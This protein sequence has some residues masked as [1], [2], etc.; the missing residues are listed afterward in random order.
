ML[1]A[2]I[3]FLFISLTI[4]F[5]ITVPVVNHIKGVSISNNTKTSYLLADVAA[6]DIL[7]R[8]KNNKQVPSNGSLSLNG[9]TSTIVVSNSGDGKAVVVTAN[10]Q[11]HIRKIS[12]SVQYGTGISFHYGIQAGQ[13][14][15]TMDNSSKI[16][17]NVFSGG[18]VIGENDNW[19]YGDVVS[20]NSSGWVYGIHATG[21][22]YSHTIGNTSYTTTVDKDAYYQTILNPSNT[23][24]SGAVCTSNSHCHPGS[25]DQTDVALPISDDQIFE[26]ETDAAAGGTLSSSF[27]DSFSSNTCFITTSKSLGPIKIPFNLDIKSNGGIL[28]VNGPIWVVGN[29]ITETGATI[30]M[31]SSLGSQNVAIIADN[32]SN[33]S[34]ASTISTGQS[35]AF[36]GSGSPSSFV[37]LISM[38]N[39]AENGG[40]TVAVTM[41]QGSNA[42]VAYASH[43]LIR[44]SQ[45]VGVKE[46]TGYKISLS[47]SANVTYDTGLP[48]TLFE[49][50]PSGGYNILGWGEI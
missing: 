11:N 38:N 5:G 46:A 18:S 7:Y 24:V 27:C 9:A 42:L 23:K 8:L 35:S 30:K 49:A 39:S 40:S 19:I 31:A 16:I 36:Q 45:S 47:Q 22:V 17:G 25:A 21:T 13:G 12:A 43:G 48:N 28:T 41:S 50:G 26:W 10:S 33:R 3:F 32:P 29:I 37:F 34:T 44:M 14:G 6:E 1:L 4:I 2:T 20:A 15:F